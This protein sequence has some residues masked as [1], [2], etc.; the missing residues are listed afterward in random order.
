RADP[1]PPPSPTRR[2]SDLPANPAAAGNCN[3]RIDPAAVSHNAVMADI[4]IAGDEDSIFDTTS[5]MDRDMVEN[6]ASL[7]YAR[8][9]V[10]HD[11]RMHIACQC[12]THGAGFL[13]FA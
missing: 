6:D 8:V 4:H 11:V 10:T 12:V 9:V 1:R 2:S 3:T 5:R 13:A 7:S